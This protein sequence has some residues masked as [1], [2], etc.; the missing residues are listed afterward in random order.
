MAAD[1]DNLL[2][3]ADALMRRRRIFLAGANDADGAKEVAPAASTDDDVPLLTDVVG[4][5]AL[6]EAAI[7]SVVDIAALRRELA[8]RIE[9]WL[10]EQLPSHVQ[11][12]MDGVTDQLILRLSDKARA[13]L[14]PHLQE[15]LAAAREGTE[16][17]ATDD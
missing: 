3:K 2:Q 4:P 15:I 12:V 1:D 17:A 5:D 16:P 14:L 9:S 6:P 13:E 10:D 7:S 8:A 11:H